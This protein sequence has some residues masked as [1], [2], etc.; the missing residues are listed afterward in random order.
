VRSAIS[1]SVLPSLRGRAR[2]LVAQAQVEGVEGLTVLLGVANEA[3]MARTEEFVPEVARLLSTAAGRAVDVALVVAGVDRP[4][5]SPASASA[6]A[7]ASPEGDPST[8]SVPPGS[9]PS[10]SDPDS[11]PGPVGEPDDDLDVLDVDELEDASDVA[12]T[13]VARLTQA[14]PG[15][16]V[17]DDEAAS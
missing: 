14:F 7:P 5:R 11:D 13:G 17:V 8:P 12:T 1:G 9:P 3:T 4:P 2:A 10:A 15:A 16:V 6:P